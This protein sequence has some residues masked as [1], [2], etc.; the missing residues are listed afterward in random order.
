VQS[1]R[2]LAAD[3]ALID[4]AKSGRAISTVQLNKAAASIVHSFPLNPKEVMPKAGKYTMLDQQQA[5]KIKPQLA[6]WLAQQLKLKGDP[7]LGGL[8]SCIRKCKRKRQPVRLLEIV[9]I[10]RNPVPV[11]LS[12]ETDKP[13]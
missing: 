11:R 8:D 6:T 2:D 13:I 3:A 4:I 9:E 5:E 12:S 7:N 10:T 1:G